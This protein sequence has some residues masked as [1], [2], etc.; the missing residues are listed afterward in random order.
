MKKVASTSMT[1]RATIGALFFVTGIFLIVFGLSTARLHS[2]TPS[3]GTLNSPGPQVNWVGTAVGGGSLDESTC[4]EGV[5]C[6]TF[7]LT[8]SG[9]PTN[10]AGLKA[11]ITIS[12]ADP[13]AP[14]AHDIYVPKRDKP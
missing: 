13:S 4:F 8:W 6:D 9:P 3:S 7:L 10:W 12:C 5:N 11:R 14:S 2:A 1:A